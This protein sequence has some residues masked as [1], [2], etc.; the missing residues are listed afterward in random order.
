MLALMALAWKGGWRLHIKKY[1]WLLVAFVGVAALS[2]THEVL[3]IVGW[4]QLVRLAWFI[5]FFF[6]LRQWAFPRFNL[7]KEPGIMKNTA[8]DH[9]TVHAPT[10]RQLDPLRTTHHVT[11]TDA[12]HLHIVCHL[13]RATNQIPMR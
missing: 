9:N 8:A 10:V 4:Y 13:C 5:L 11:I 6:Y 3:P 1:D 2:L 12:K 7:G